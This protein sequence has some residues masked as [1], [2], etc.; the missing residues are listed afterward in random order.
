MSFFRVLVGDYSQDAGSGLD[1]DEVERQYEEYKSE[2]DAG[3]AK[4]WSGS[5]GEEM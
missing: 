3:G 1:A 4:W 5:D 2:S